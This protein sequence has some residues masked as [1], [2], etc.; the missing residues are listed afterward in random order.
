M[1]LLGGVAYADSVQ[2]PV[3][4][5]GDS[6]V[7]AITT[8]NGQTGWTQK[9]QQISVERVNHQDILVTFNQKGS[10]Q[11]PLEA[12]RGFDW[13]RMGDVNGKQQVVHQPLSFPLSE[14]KKW[15]L[16]YKR[17]NPTPK[18][19]SAAFDCTYV[20][21]GW[22]EVQVPAGKFN[23]LKIECNGEWKEEL[24]PGVT[25]TSAGSTTQGGTTAVA[26]SQTTMQ[27]SVSGRIYQA[28]WYVPSVKR[29]VKSL[30][31]SYTS[32]GNRS[33]RTTEEMISFTPGT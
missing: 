23:A 8:E 14:N 12:L 6:W 5:A 10:N 29:Y 2:A 19:S 32:G 9:Q 25:F 13:S 26:Q 18:L 28:Y 27:H 1:S 4:K 22:E 20:A 3:F 15:E 17:S 24:A 30:E 31:E 11:P 16:S 21:T 7:Y 33:S